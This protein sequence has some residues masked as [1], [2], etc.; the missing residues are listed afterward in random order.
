[1]G[2]ALLGEMSDVSRVIF[3][4]DAATARAALEAAYATRGE[5]WTMIVPRRPLPVRFSEAEA[6]E[7]VAR[8]GLRLPEVSGDQLQLVA[9]GAYQLAEVLRASD[10]LTRRGVEHG[11]TCLLEPGRFR[12]PRDARERGVMAPADVRAHLLPDVPTIVVTHTRAEPML[13]LLS[14][15]RRSTR[16]LRVL[17]YT[18]HGGTLDVAGML[19]ANG[20][21]AEDILTVATELVARR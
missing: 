11:V 4:A 20:C 14:A 5:I 21:T 15:G 1:M 12:A 7:L 9:V 18:N 16:P 8:G 13:G 17:G 19:R 3:V 6:R 10:E 2:E